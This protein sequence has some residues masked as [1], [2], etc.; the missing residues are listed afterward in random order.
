MPRLGPTGTQGAPGRKRARN[1]TEKT[2]EKKCLSW[3][4]RKPG[5]IRP[6][7]DRIMRPRPPLPMPYI[8]FCICMKFFSRRF[9][10]ATW[11]PD[12]VAIRRRREPSMVFG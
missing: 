4:Q 11:V 3:A 1:Y 12:P 7:I 10:S 6:A 9:T 5:G 8:I 2:S